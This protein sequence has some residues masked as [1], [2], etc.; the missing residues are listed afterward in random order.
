MEKYSI[1]LQSVTIQHTAKVLNVPAKH[2]VLII[3]N[4]TK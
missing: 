3:N 1:Y 4:L 2:F